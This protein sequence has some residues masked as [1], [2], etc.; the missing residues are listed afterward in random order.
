MCSICEAVREQTPGLNSGFANLVAGNEA[1]ASGASVT[2]FATLTD[3]TALLVSDTQP[4]HNGNDQIT[5]SFLGDT[6]PDYYPTSGGAWEVSEGTTLD[7][8]SDVAMTAAEEQMTRLAIEMLNEMANI[9]MVEGTINNSEFGDI[10]LGSAEFAD[11]GLFGFV[12]DFPNPSDLGTTPSVFGDTWLNRNNSDQYL[13]GVGP[14][15]GHTSWNTIIHELGHALGLRHPNES[16]ND[17]ET[18]TQYT[19]MSY[20]PHPSVAD[21][22]LLYQSFSLTAMVWDIQALQEMYGANTTT[23]T[24]DTAYFGD[25]VLAGAVANA[26]AETEY[27]YGESDMRVTG[28]DG[29]AREVILTIWDAGGDDTIDASDLTTNSMIDLAPGAYSTIGNIENNIAVAAAVE[30][31]GSVINYVE[32]AWGGAGDDTIRGNAADNQLLGLGGTDLLSGLGG[33]DD[34]DGGD[35]NDTAYGGDGND[36][37]VGGAG[38]DLGGGGAGDDSMDGQGGNDSLFG[39]AGNDTLSGGDGNDLLGGAGGNDSLSGGAGNDELWGAADNDT[40]SGDDGADTLGGSTGDDQAFGGAGNDELWGAIGNDTLSGGADNDTLGGSTGNDMLSGDAGE[41]ELWGSSG[42]DSLSGGDDDDRLGGGID[43][44]NV[45]GGAGND[46]L[47][48]GAGNDTLMGD[49]G[50]DTLFGAA[51]DDYLMGGTGADAIYAGPGADDIIFND[52]DGADTL[53]FFSLTDDALVLDSTIWGGGLTAQQVVDTYGADSGN[54][55]VLDF[56]DGDI[57]T[58]SDQAGANIVGALDIV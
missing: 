42:A 18:N 10:V 34:I 35:G 11:P 15:Y 33:D 55:Y 52:G 39:A 2:N 37:I 3:Y 24:G 21:Q 32:N 23:R 20:I 25:G 1:D 36:T 50:N 16:P 19:M 46:E 45:A 54:D 38:D 56:G 8:G 30:E 7:V 49:A 6:M 4:W 53:Y 14:V 58:F 44:D 17:S 29:I 40:L 9:N 26:N 51:G 57:V 12:S 5:F 31:Q 22:S 43:D 48:G 28:G 41:D 47:F 27:Q 13:P